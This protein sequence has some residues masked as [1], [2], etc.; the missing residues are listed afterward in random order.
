MTYF[1]DSQV[2]FMTGVRET[3][4]ALGMDDNHAWHESA[5]ILS[6]WEC[7]DI[8]SDWE[9]ADEDIEARL[10]VLNQ[11]QRVVTADWKYTVGSE[12]PLDIA[13]AKH[14]YQRSVDL[15]GDINYL[16]AYTRKR[17]ILMTY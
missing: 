1:D 11:E 17:G 14:L 13:E 2:D 12:N 7:A 10:T 5:D 3:L 15:Q 9:C 4:I 8:L 16:E 6:D